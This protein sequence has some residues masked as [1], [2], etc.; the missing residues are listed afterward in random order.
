LDQQ[1]QPDLEFRDE[2]GRS[3]RLGQYFEERPIILVLAQ[4][5]CPML[6]TQVLNGLVRAMLDLPFEAGKEFTV[7]TVSFDS[8]ETPEL[9]AAKKQTYLERY[10]RPGAEAG[11]HFLV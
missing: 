2:M 6:C 5:R 1:V 4:Y 9:A 7:I 11:W 3:V 8:R 10:G